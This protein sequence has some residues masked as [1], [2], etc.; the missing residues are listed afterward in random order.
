MEIVLASASPRRAELL[1]KVLEEFEIKKSDYEENNESDIPPSELVKEHSLNKARRVEG[2]IVIGADTIVAMD[3]KVLGKPKTEE[4]AYDMLSKQS[5]R[6]IDVLSGIAVVSDKEYTDV[7]KT[8]VKVKELTD[9][10]IRNYIS[11]GEPMD[12]AGAFG[13]QDR[14]SLLVEKVDGDFFNVVGLPLFRLSG[15][16]K[17]AGVKL[18]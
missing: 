2:D 1:A 11:T 17:K 9:E 5:G 8:R 16:L 18:L 14:G 3:D 12:K 13:I 15:L 10:E 7:V 4:E 6:E